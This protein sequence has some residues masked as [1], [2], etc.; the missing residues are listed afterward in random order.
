VNKGDKMRAFTKYTWTETK[1]YLRQ[2][3]GAFFTLIFPLMI[4]FLFGSLHGNDPLPEYNGYGTVDVSIPAYIG[5]IIGTT[6]IMVLTVTMSAYREKGVLRRLRATPLQPQVIVIAQVVVIFM[7]TVAGMLLLILAGKLV[8]NLRFDGNL[9]SVALA[10]I[11]GSLSFFSL[12]FVLAGVMPNAR[13]AQVVGLVILYPMIF[14][15][16][17]GFP[18]EMMPEGIR[19]FSNFLP[20]THVV[21]LL[22]GLWTGDTLGQHI[23]EIIILAS[24]IVVSMLVSTMTFKWE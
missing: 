17:A 11:L 1:L 2:P 6:G 19:K 4:L 22:R 8:Y 20:L 5:M 21:T 16:G 14:L 13:T 7:M 10:F 18:L 3:I 9:L 23:T 12:G 24:L 15:S